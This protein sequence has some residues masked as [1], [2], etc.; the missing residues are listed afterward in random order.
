MQLHKKFETTQPEIDI[1]PMVDVM[2]II[3]V[4]LMVTSTFVL[5]P[6]FKIEL[7]EATVSDNN[8]PEILTLYITKDKEIFLNDK[9]V[10]LSTVG[11]E[12]QK[13][14]PTLKNNA[15]AINADYRA[16]YGLIIKLTDIAKI[17]GVQNL[18]FTTQPYTENNK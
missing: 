6:G 2:F 14:L 7:P 5:Q 4:F 18:I 11:A 13:I 9:K 15:L 3:L 16:E 8:P 12:I 1:A 10:D 17:A